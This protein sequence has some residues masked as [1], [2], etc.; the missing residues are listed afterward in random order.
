MNAISTGWQGTDTPHRGKKNTATR[1]DKLENKPARWHKPQK[2]TRGLHQMS[3]TA[4]CEVSEAATVDRAIST[5]CN[6]GGQPGQVSSRQ[7]SVPQP[8]K[9]LPP[10]ALLVLPLPPLVP[11]PKADIAAPLQALH[12]RHKAWCHRRSPTLPARTNHLHN[13]TA[14]NFGGGAC[15]E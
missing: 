6:V 4:V 14:Q 10:P 3:Q 9:Q 8:V 2:L 5:Q 11:Q 15:G 13:D 7:R 1:T 12:L